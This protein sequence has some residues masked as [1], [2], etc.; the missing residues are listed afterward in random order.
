MIKRREIAA[1]VQR[2]SVH[3]DPM[4]NTNPDRS[5]L[6]ILDPNSG[7]RF[8]SLRGDIVPARRS[9]SSC[10]SQRKYLCKSWPHRRRSIIG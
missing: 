3:R 2:E 6:T 8:A 9:M 10:S 5:D 7:E 4:A 1:H